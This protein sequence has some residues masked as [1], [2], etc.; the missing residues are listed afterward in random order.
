MGRANFFILLLFLIPT[1]HAQ[2]TSGSH[3]YFVNK[4][5]SISDTSTT[6][7]CYVEGVD[8]HWVTQFLSVSQNEIF[9]IAPT[10]LT[11][12]PQP[13]S[14]ST[15]WNA[16]I[17]VSDA[18][19]NAPLI[20]SITDTSQTVFIQ[21]GQDTSGFL[22]DPNAFSLFLANPSDLNPFPDV[23]IPIATRDT[24]GYNASSETINAEYHIITNSSI[25]YNRFT[26][27]LISYAMH[28][29]YLDHNESHDF[30]IS[31]TSQTPSQSPTKLKIQAFF[32]VYVLVFA[33][34][35]QKFR[36]SRRK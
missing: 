13:Q 36:V 18:H 7:G 27:F 4:C 12:D 23:F 1:V 3:N 35:L 16:T 28:F 9:T 21:D 30:R 5:T 34:Y 15:T 22:I 8:Q 17:F 31:S 20:L 25:L 2:Q 29:E 24:I 10:D 14:F 11:P 6:Y 26:G 32:P 19:A 33:A